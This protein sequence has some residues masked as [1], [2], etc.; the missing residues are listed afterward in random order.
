MSNK[1]RKLEPAEAHADALLK[2]LE[3]GDLLVA[4]PGK[5]CRHGLA[6]AGSTGLEGRHDRR[7]SGDRN[8]CDGWRLSRGGL[9]G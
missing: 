3:T 4:E 5:G 7:R 9:G 6:A 8:G 1:V 2:S